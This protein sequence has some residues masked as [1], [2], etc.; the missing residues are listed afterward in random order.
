MPDIYELQTT[1]GERLCEIF[2]E[3][4]RLERTKI[5]S[6]LYGGE[7]L[8]QTIGSPTRIKTLQI[9]AWDRD[10]QA[11]V[12]EAE[13]RND[14]LDA[15]LGDVTVRGF[16]LDA[17]EWSAVVNRIGIYEATVKFVVIET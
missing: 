2:G 11:A 17:P 6:K 10:E 5:A 7:Y 8:V 16:L 15:V 13:A 9:R 1:D 4:E 14:L 3:S 12:N